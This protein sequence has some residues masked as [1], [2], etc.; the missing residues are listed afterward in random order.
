MVALSSQ[1]SQ[2][3]PRVL[4]G[5]DR[6][7]FAA[8][9]DQFYLSIYYFTKK[10]V[11]DPQAAEDLTADSFVKLWNKALQEN[12]V[13]NVRAFLYSVARNACLDYLKTH[14]LHQE[15]HKEILYLAEEESRIAA[16]TSEIKAELLLEIREEIERLPAK[17]RQIFKLAFFD[18]L[19][20]S[21]IAAL[22]ALSEQTVQNQK[23]IA[24]KRLRIA[25]QNKAWAGALLL[26]TFLLKKS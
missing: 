6:K 16:Y 14:Q 19:K 20:N 17:A 24:L 8:L 21:E 15:K 5:N 12:E 4:T 3:S 18:G 7:Q 26:S 2:G 10:I 11:A 13:N 22:L 23:S 9:Y 1:D 25:F